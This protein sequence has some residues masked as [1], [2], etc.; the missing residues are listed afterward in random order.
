M[1]E[2]LRD[3]GLDE[4]KRGD[5]RGREKRKVW[6]RGS[7]EDEGTGNSCLGL[8]ASWGGEVPHFPVWALVDRGGK[9]ME[10]D[11]LGLD[12]AWLFSGDS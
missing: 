11:G 2:S 1:F 8:S 5:E 3:R 12:F 4:L 9:G 6:D 7:G 10:I